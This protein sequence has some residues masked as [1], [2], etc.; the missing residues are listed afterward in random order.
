[1]RL[2]HPQV[3]QALIVEPA[4]EVPPGYQD[5]IMPPNYGATLSRQEVDALVKYLA[6]VS[7]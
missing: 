1:M 7:M 5:G 4:A 3:R 2:A 6:G